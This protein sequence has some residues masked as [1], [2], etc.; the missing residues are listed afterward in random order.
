MIKV[1]SDV[2]ITQDGIDIDTEVM[3]LVPK[4]APEEAVQFI[5]KHELKALLTHLY[6]KYPDIVVDAIEDF[7]GGLK[8]D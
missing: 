2:T 4:T 7:A 8:D 5:C 6:K 1:N 3:V